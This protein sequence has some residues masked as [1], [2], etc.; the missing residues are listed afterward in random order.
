MS[1]FV[2]NLLLA[3]AWAAIW[4]SFSAATLAVGFVLGFGALW[5][6]R[7][8]TGPSRYHGRVRELGGFAAFY[9]GE[10]ILSALRVTRLVLSPGLRMRPGI[11]AVPL[12]ARTD[13][14]ITTF[15][16]LVS[17]TPGTLSLDLSPDRRTLY[18][19]AMDLGPGGPDALRAELKDGLERRV[20]SLFR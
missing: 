16:N 9:L 13:A 11:V 7:P 4:G 1:P 19:H 5:L 6:A 3:L 15:A 10:L 20:V 17:L 18:V 2:V 12:D 14:E 8:V